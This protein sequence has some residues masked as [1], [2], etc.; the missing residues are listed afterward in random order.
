MKSRRHY[1]R[2]GRVGPLGQLRA[3]Q[4]VG[5][6]TP[7]LLSRAVVALVALQVEQLFDLLH[8]VH[9]RADHD[10]DVVVRTVGR[11]CGRVADAPRASSLRRV[12][13][14]AVSVV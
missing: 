1:Q 4:R 13:A 12:K 14:D 10:D 9:A 3:L 11:R 6:R 2:L 8:D 7:G 5:A